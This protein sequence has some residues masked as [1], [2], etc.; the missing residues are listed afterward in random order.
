MIITPYTSRTG[1]KSTLRSLREHGWRILV[2]A[3]GK[4]RHEGFRYG[5]DN[6]AWTAHQ[7]GRAFNASRFEVL[8][9]R[10]GSGADWIVVPDVVGDRVESLRMTDRWFGRVSELGRPVLVA[11]QDG[12]EPT[13]LEPWVSEGAGVFLGGS[14][15]WKLDTMQA[16]GDWCHDRGAYYHVARVNSQKRIRAC[17][18]AR[19]HSFDGTSPI[20]FPVNIPKL[21]RACWPRQMT[22]F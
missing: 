3:T 19:A 15:E 8:L 10:L 11:A 2:S 22:L 21:T 16:W 17:I 18:R 7:Q 13:D 6:G 12:M 1:T 9:E 5:I 4:H 14:T 20:M